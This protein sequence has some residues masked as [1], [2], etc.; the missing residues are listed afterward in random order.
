MTTTTTID[1]LTDLTCDAYTV[2]AVVR[3]D[4]IVASYH[5]TAADL[6][7]AELDGADASER[8]AGVLDAAGYTFSDAGA[9]DPGI[10]EVWSAT[11]A[12]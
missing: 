11:A 9:D 10:Y 1:A 3:G 8:I 7:Q 2:V 5:T 12:D 4:T 6:A